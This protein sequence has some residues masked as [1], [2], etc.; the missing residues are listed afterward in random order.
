M[1]SLELQLRQLGSVFLRYLPTFRFVSD[2]CYE[3]NRRY[4][5]V[6]IYSCVLV[7]L[8][9][10]LQ[11]CDGNDKSYEHVSLYPACRAGDRGHGHRYARDE[12][13]GG[14]RGSRMSRFAGSAPRYIGALCRGEA[15]PL[16]ALHCSWLLES[17]FLFRW[18]FYGGGGAIWKRCA[19]TEDIILVRKA[20]H[21]ESRAPSDMA[22]GARSSTT[23]CNFAVYFGYEEGRRFILV[24]AADFIFFNEVFLLYSPR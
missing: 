18:G 17:V 4:S 12:L 3:F 19:S 21:V 13:R 22:W 9:S 5:I 15:V 23:F 7:P 10:F 2:S 1:K 16:S 11:E 20:W 8:R 24:P 6:P 14:P